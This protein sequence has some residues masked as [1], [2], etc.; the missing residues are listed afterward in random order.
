MPEGTQETEQ[1]NSW[2]AADEIK[3][4]NT[5]GDYIDTKERR[6]GRKTTRL[7]N[8]GRAF[9][10]QF[11]SEQDDAHLLVKDQLEGAQGEKKTFLTLLEKSVRWLE[12]TKIQDR[13]EASNSPWKKLLSSEEMASAYQGL[14]AKMI[15]NMVLVHAASV[16]S[17]I[18][19][20]AR[21]DDLLYAQIEED[22]VNKYIVDAGNGKKISE[23]RPSDMK[24]FFEKSKR[25]MGALEMLEE[26]SANAPER[27]PVTPG[28]REWDERFMAAGRLGILK[29]E[30]AEMAA[31][32][33]D[34]LVEIRKKIKVPSKRVLGPVLKLAAVSALAA[35]FAFGAEKLAGDS[36]EASP[37]TTGDATAQVEDLPQVPTADLEI[38]SW[39]LDELADE[40]TKAGALA[41][42]ITILFN[43]RMPHQRVP[44]Y[45]RS[46]PVVEG[47][48]IDSNGNAIFGIA[49]KEGTTPESAL[50]AFARAHI[51]GLIYDSG[52]LREISGID[53]IEEFRQNESMRRLDAMLGL[54]IEKY[55][56]DNGVG[57]NEFYFAI[58]GR[59]PGS[60]MNAQDG[61][62]VDAAFGVLQEYVSGF[63]E[64]LPEAEDF[65]DP[66]KLRSM[67][68]AF[69]ATANLNSRTL[70][71]D[72]FAFWDNI[73]RY[74][75]GK[76]RINEA[77]RRNP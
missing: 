61:D 12:A 11:W 6:G 40:S 58:D 66:Q 35:S 1:T 59:S 76:E 2:S 24:A 41:G 60:P 13:L 67:N 68:E 16:S 71:P 15:E 18:R 19:D 52:Q 10:R 28:E 45:I 44:D 77:P 39:V 73:E 65:F 50:T 42:D 38:G 34:K 62:Y 55:K 33:R 22:L 32:Y 9:A 56:Y 30:V 54:A 4:S 37:P 48:F 27:T 23:A 46:F 43:P 36:S 51:L 49:D 5:F 72:N 75:P 74:A 57:G 29:Y 47:P 63:W 8:E 20:F 53:S 69:L 31:Q 7:S 26:A 3:F 17:Q 25:S 70:D 21:G 64:Q 14:S